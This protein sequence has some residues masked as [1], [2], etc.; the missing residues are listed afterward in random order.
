[1][2]IYTNLSEEENFFYELLGKNDKHNF[3]FNNFIKEF[4]QFD[5]FRISQIFCDEFIYLK[6]KILNNKEEKNII[7]FEI[8]DNLYSLTQNETEEINYKYIFENF[9][10]DIEKLPLK[11][12]KK[13]N[14]L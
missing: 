1:M 12:F 14:N 4:E 3:Y 5:E 9:K 8:I 2:N 11:K 7:Y 10:S 13:N 6:K